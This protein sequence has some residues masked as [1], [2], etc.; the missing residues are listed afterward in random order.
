MAD[1]PE[2][3]AQD[4]DI[5]PPSRDRDLLDRRTTIRDSLEKLFNKIV[6]GFEAQADRSDD[7]EKW[8]RIYHCELDDQQFFNGTAA[9][10]VP[11]IHDAID[12]RVT[13]FSNQLFPVSGQY[14]DCTTTDGHL[15]YEIL[16]LI[17]H[18][19]SQAH[20]QTDVVEPLLLNADIEGQMNLYIDWNEVCRQIVSRETRKPE[21]QTAGGPAPAEGIEIEDI[22]TEDV[23]E[24]CPGF[25]VLHDSDVLILPA[26]AANVEDALQR[27]GCAV[28]VRRWT[29]EDIDAMAASGDIRDDAADDLKKQGMFADNTMHGLSDL[30][31]KLIKT[32]GIKAQ[33][34]H[35]IVF[36]V[37][38]MLPLND[39][40]AYA[41]SGTKRICRVYLGVGRQQL[42]AKRNP[43]WND[44]VPL[45]S[46][47][48]KKVAG[49]VKGQSRVEPVA[50]IQYEANDAAN[51]RADV[52]HYS[53][54]PIVIRKPGEYNRPLIL[55]LGAVWDED[56]ANIKF[57]EFPDL[58]ARGRARIQDAMQVIFQSLGVNPSML[59]QQTGR[60]GRGRNQAEVALEQ[61]VDLLQTA[62]AVGPVGDLMTEVSAFVVD[63]DHQ[64]RD[65]DMTIRAF[66]E[67]GVDAEL[68]QVGP[69]QNRAAVKIT[70]NGAEQA[71]FNAAMQ[72]Q[73][74]AF[75]NVARGLSQQL[76]NEGYELRIGPLLEKSAMNLFGAKTARLMLIDRRRQQSM[77]PELEN[78]MLL[79]GMEVSVHKMDM[80]QKHLEV[81]IPLMQQSGDPTGV[82]KLHVQ[83]HLT[84]LS[85]KNAAMQ[86]AMLPGHMG[87]GLPAGG[88]GVPGGAGKGV[89]GAP[90]MGA[91][92]GMSRM[93]GPPGMLHQ[94]RLMRAGGGSVVPMPRK[95]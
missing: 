42:G 87:A 44:R 61:S 37:W 49:S 21:V 69:L 30:T 32:V 6:K 51:E 39:D 5:Q 40:G 56:P 95:M 14:I 36:E 81:H 74:I 62:R 94:D 70:W 59:P 86:Q 66:G 43:Y 75:V 50:P 52:D 34:K 9:V 20:V 92:P 41:K 45:F 53:A 67:L 13:R 29:E 23:T 88:E 2:V 93:Q 31:K 71:R 68:I 4:E 63:L 47:P 10:Y 80:D 25:E 57:V 72:Q 19:Y 76:M 77:D 58:S 83:M 91:Q 18:Y 7:L 82:I 35:T 84:Q 17:D 33:G 65:K 15:P 11:I 79:E 28:I 64:F 54:M 22:V 38:T 46:K 90:R 60:P 78:E 27:G 73:G 48:G 55:N 85:A 1:E 8:W 89:A 12:A 24:G 3:A 16:A 26:N